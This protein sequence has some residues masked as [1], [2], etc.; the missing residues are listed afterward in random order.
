MGICIYSNIEVQSEKE[1]KEYV[2]ERE[3]ADLSDL[4]QLYNFLTASKKLTIATVTLNIKTEVHR[5]HNKSSRM[6]SKEVFGLDVREIYRL[7]HSFHQL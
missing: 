7:C 5:V 4:R 6:G 1:M 3:K 2:R